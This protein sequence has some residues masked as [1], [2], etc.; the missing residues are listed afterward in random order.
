LFR[1]KAPRLCASNPAIKAD[2][3]HLLRRI[4]G[5]RAG[6]PGA[7]PCSPSSRALPSGSPAASP[8]S[9]ACSASPS[10]GAAR[11]CPPGPVSRNWRT[12]LH[13]AL[14]QDSVP[15]GCRHRPSPNRFG[16]SPGT[17][18]AGNPQRRAA[19]TRGHPPTSGSLETA[20]GMAPHSPLSARVR[21]RLR[22]RPVFR[23]AELSAR[24][25]HIQKTGPRRGPI[26]RPSFPPVLLANPY[27]AVPGGG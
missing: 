18:E 1:L 24:F 4:P 7:C 17:G 3:Y 20:C 10:R 2:D 23:R 12:H 21:D 22:P 6:T 13:P 26:A 16:I 27:P 15:R 11:N 5:E 19:G 14:L 9:A 8:L 25:R